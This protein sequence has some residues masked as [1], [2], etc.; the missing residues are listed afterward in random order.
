MNSGVSSG[1]PA[2]LLSE[3]IDSELQ[4]GC[5]DRDYNLLSSEL[6]D[7]HSSCESCIALDDYQ[8]ISTGPRDCITCAD[9]S[10]IL[11]TYWSDG[12]GICEAPVTDYDYD[13]SNGG[14]VYYYDSG[15]YT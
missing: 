3:N 5:Y 7:C 4:P 9:S 15:D 12:T 2:Q 11:N 14:G 1:P 10:Y 6:C 8:T 13:Y